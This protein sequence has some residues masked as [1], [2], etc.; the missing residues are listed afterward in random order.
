MQQATTKLRIYRIE[1][2]RFIM[3]PYKS[4]LSVPSSSAA[5]NQQVA[6]GNVPKELVKSR[7]EKTNKRIRALQT[8]R[9]G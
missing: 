2:L 4:K 5:G 6:R 9:R 8:V 1:V 3:N 7:E